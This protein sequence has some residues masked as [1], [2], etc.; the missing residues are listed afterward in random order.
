MRIMNEVSFLHAHD[1]AVNTMSLDDPELFEYPV[2]YIIEV[3]L[4]DDDR[5]PRR[6]ALR[7]YIKKGGFV[8]VDDFKARGRTS[9]AAAAGRR[10]KPTC[11]A[12]CRARSS[13]RCSASHPIFHS[14]FEINSLDTFRRPTT[15]GRRASSGCSRTTTRPSGCEMIVNYNTDISQ[16]WEWSGQGIR[17]IDDTNEAYKLGVNY[18]IYGLTH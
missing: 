3:E 17:P 15:P 16:Y 13:S 5:P 4:V 6:A 11:S 14:F 12:S 8:I 2:A 1:D 7:E 9:A 10:S 18:I